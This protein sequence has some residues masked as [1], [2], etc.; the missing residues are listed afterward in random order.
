MSRLPKIAL[1]TL[2]ACC[3]ALLLAWAAS[4]VHSRYKAATE[5]I[6]ELEARVSE[7]KASTHPRWHVREGSFSISTTDK[8]ESTNGLRFRLVYGTN[9]VQK[10]EDHIWKEPGRVMTAWVSDWTPRSEM[11]KFE[12]FDVVPS[13]EGSRFEVVAKTR[14]DESIEMDFYADL[15]CGGRMVTQANKPAAPNAGIASQL[16]IN[17]SLARRR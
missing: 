9:D 12:R 10:F 5:H 4:A 15:Y 6:S 17:T 2:A 3:F 11:S 14:P 1:I 8:T 16:T 13:R 7:L